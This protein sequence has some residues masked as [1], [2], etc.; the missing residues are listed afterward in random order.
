MEPLV[1][2]EALGNDFFLCEG[3]V[4]PD[5]EEIK[6]LCSH[7]GTGADGL[8]YLQQH[9]DHFV[10]NIFNADGT[11]GGLSG[12]GLRCAALHISLT[13]P[14]EEQPYLFSTSAGD[15]SAWVKENIVELLFWSLQP[16]KPEDQ[17]VQVEW[18]EL[19]DAVAGQLK[20]VWFLDIGNPHL[21]LYL[22]D[23]DG[24]WSGL[25]EQLLEELRKEGKVLPNGINVSVLQRRSS[26]YFK[27]VVWERGV[28][29]T[30]ACASAAL[31]S[32]L[33]TR[34]LKLSESTATVEQVGGK[35]ALSHE[36]KGILLRGRACKCQIEVL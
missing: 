34:Y 20:K 5:K 14:T 23:K 29:R 28:G 21:I 12:N 25:R 17:P 22:G 31:A 9:R 1:K 8:L 11:D 18:S 6:N 36:E 27:L 3:D 35:L 15:V 4:P 24:D 7:K 33:V 2:Y 10:V 32:F 30:Q 16:T 13:R 19:N 26:D